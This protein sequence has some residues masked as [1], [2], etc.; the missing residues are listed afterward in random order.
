LTF[1]DSGASVAFEGKIRNGGKSVAKAV[2]TLGSN[3]LTEPIIPENISIDPRQFRNFLNRGLGQGGCNSDIARQMTSLGGGLLLPDGAAPWN[4]TLKTPKDKII[5]NGSGLA[6]AWTGICI[7]YQ[8]DGGNYHGTP[9][10]LIYDD[11]SSH[12]SFIPRGVVKGHFE[13]FATGA[14]AY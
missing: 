5:V 3:L 2:Q 4:R 12:D 1:D 9:L 10:I 6:S 14:D 13:I 8:D 7:F 11:E